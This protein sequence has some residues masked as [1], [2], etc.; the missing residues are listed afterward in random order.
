V[1]DTHEIE[2]ALWMPLEEFFL[3][4]EMSRFQKTLVYSAL[5]NEGLTF[6][7]SDEFF[8]SKQYVE[9]YG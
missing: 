2:L 3:H 1:I 4:E 7:D 8:S 9:V 6:L 5:E